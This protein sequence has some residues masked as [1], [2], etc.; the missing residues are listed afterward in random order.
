[1]HTS[2]MYSTCYVWTQRGGIPAAA[3]AGPRLVAADARRAPGFA[4]L[5][6]RRWLS[7][8]KEH[9]CMRTYIHIGKLR[10]HVGSVKVSDYVFYRFCICCEV[11][12]FICFMYVRVRIA[13]L[14][15]IIF[16]V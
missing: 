9:T 6:A 11:V 4:T 14:M 10:P 7:G 5:A 13:W 12:I 2:Y 16:S 8:L 15:C 1:M 3:V